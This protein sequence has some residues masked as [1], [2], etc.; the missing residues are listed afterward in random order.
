MATR[1]FLFYYYFFYLIF[2]PLDC[3]SHNFESSSRL[4]QQET[5]IFRAWA[6]AAWINV[7]Y[8]YSAASNQFTIA[9]AHWNHF[10]HRDFT[11]QTDQWQRAA[12]L[13]LPLHNNCLSFVERLVAPGLHLY[14]FQTAAG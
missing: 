8:V 11:L 2:G 7:L 10:L 4:L 5:V 14:V 9:A 1:P 6:G 13:P 12:R 3:P